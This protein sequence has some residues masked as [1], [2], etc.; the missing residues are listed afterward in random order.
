ML[1]STA[2]YESGTALN[3]DLEQMLQF[4]QTKHINEVS[5]DMKALW[6]WYA[7]TLLVKV[8]RS[9]WP[10]RDPENRNSKL[11]SECVSVGD[12]AVVLTVLQLRA[13][14]YFDLRKGKANANTP[15]TPKGRGRQKGV[16]P[17]PEKNLC[18]NIDKYM[19]F[20][21]KIESVRIAEKEDKFGW[22]AY[23]CQQ[24]CSEYSLFNG[25]T[26]RDRSKKR[27][28]VYEKASLPMDSV[29]EL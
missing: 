14:D 26:R 3:K 18:D 24:A 12:E 25:T 8:S 22:N 11:M 20:R 19:M 29:M 6:R 5:Q 28:T 23:I 21:E 4:R 17:D 10:W 7:L 13:Q 9:T 2:T 1:L 15:T 16:V 27:R